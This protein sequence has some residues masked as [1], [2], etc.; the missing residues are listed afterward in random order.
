MNEIRHAKVADL[1]VQR[2]AAHEGYEYARRN[3]IPVG[4]AKQC[5]VAVYEIP[6]GKAGF[7]YHY[8]TKNEEVFYI[9]SGSGTLKTP[10]GERAVGAGE[11]L[12]FPA[13]ERGAH[14]LTNASGVE[15]LVYIDFDTHNELEVAFYPDSGKVGIWG[16]DINQVY[17]V[18]DRVGYYEGE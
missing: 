1:E 15:P 3:F 10:D 9:L 6:P 5:A 8:H 18:E 7:P 11:M 4:G 2:K 13:N 12:Y 14:K 17:R 16:M